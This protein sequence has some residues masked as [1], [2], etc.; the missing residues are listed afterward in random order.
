[1]FADFL[2]G[3]ATSYLVLGTLGVVAVI[4]L[5]IGHVPFGDRLP[6]I[7]PYVVLAQFVAYPFLMLL[8][9]LIGFRL[10]DERAELK[11][12]KLNLAFSELQLNAQRSVAVAATNLK[13]KAEAEA[14]TMATRANEFEKRNT[15]LDKKASDYADKL[16]KRAPDSCGLTADDI[17]SL[18][19]IAR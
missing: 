7:A 10:S 13:Q 3:M 6:V 14:S 18:Y 12:V 19:G 15:D 2:W 4:A 17:R 11:Q 8:A 9:F 1:V 5:V 16:A